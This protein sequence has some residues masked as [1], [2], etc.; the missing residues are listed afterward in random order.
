ML[1]LRATTQGERVAT[2]WRRSDQ[3]LTTTTSFQPLPP[4]STKVTLKQL[5]S[6]ITRQVN[7]CYEQCRQDMN[8]LH[9]RVFQDCRE[10]VSAELLSLETSFVE[11]LQTALAKERTAVDTRVG[12]FEEA[13]QKLSFEFNEHRDQ[14]A[15]GL[16]HAKQEAADAVKKVTEDIT[17]FRLRTECAM[18]DLVR[19]LAVQKVENAVRANVHGERLDTI[20]DELMAS[21]AS[22]TADL[23]AE[24]K[25]RE[26]LE[27]WSKRA[28]QDSHEKETEL[29]ESVQRHKAG[30]DEQFDEIRRVASELER[31]L[32][33]LLTAKAEEQHSRIEEVRSQT[34][35][36][37]V[38]LRTSSE[39]LGE[40]LTSTREDLDILGDRCVEEFSFQH[41]TWARRVD[42]TAQVDIEQL[43]L[44]GKLEV[45]SP[46]F[47]ASGIE[48]LQLV[49]R[50]TRGSDPPAT[51]GKTRRW[52]CGAFLRAARGEVAFRLHVAGQEQVFCNTF[53][54]P[55]ECGAH[56][57]SLVSRL[58]PALVVRLE[59]LDVLAPVNMSNTWPQALSAS[60]RIPDATQSASKDVRKV[61]TSVQAASKDCRRL[62]LRVAQLYGRVFPAGEAEEELPVS[63]TGGLAGAFNSVA[64][65]WTPRSVDAQRLDNLSQPRRDVLASPA[66]S[67]SH[68]PSP[69]P[70]DTAIE[71][72]SRQR[73][74]ASVSDAFTLPILARTEARARTM[75]AAVSSAR[76]PRA[77]V[78]S[79]NLLSLR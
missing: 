42:W 8:D 25:L 77:G 58:N 45:E 62:E 54:S 44:E 11:Q 50:I 56:R 69:S 64:N 27:C 49:L 5:E 33:S 66:L 17:P 16:Q 53:P 73:L 61:I 19:D 75:P 60:L 6:E 48:M 12:S 10:N 41:A 3:N 9:E 59:I 40:R 1:P 23:E 21:I 2:V 71:K 39:Q 68:S 24:K 30:V 65:Q 57:M 46:I 63:P 31:R 38:A 74:E 34:A 52:V 22:I 47:K 15:G 26:G 70:S 67:Y 36:E 29:A 28:R 14:L 55:P 18:Q 35:S 43:E 13:L 7:H 32:S 79:V 72:P 37:V 4:E 20:A 78:D 76:T 51:D